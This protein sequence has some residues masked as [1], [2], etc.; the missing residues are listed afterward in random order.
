MPWPA[1]RLQ[2]GAGRLSRFGFIIRETLRNV[3]SNWIEAENLEVTP[4]IHVPGYKF[5]TIIPYG[6][7]LYDPHLCNWVAQDGSVPI[8]DVGGQPR[9]TIFDPHHGHGAIWWLRPDDR[10]E[11]AVPWGHVQLGMPMFPRCAPPSFG[12]WA[13]HFLILA[14]LHPGRA[15]AHWDHVIQKWDGRSD[16][17]ETFAI[18]P[19]NN[20]AQG[21][22]IPS[23]LIPGEFGPDGTEYEGSYFCTALRNNT[24]YRI[25]GNGRSESHVIL[26]GRDNPSLLPR[27]F[28]F[29]SGDN[30]PDFPQY[31]GK[32]IV[33]GVPNTN[34]TATG[35]DNKGRVVGQD[36]AFHVIEDGRCSPEPF[37]VGNR[38]H[39]FPSR[40][41][42]TFGPL[43]NSL[44]YTD[45]GSIMQSQS[46][47][48]FDAYPHDAGVH[49]RDQGGTLRPFVTDLRSGRNDMQFAGN[50]LL[51]TNW[52]KSYST[53]EF[54][55]ADGAIWEIVYD[56][57]GA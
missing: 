25:F 54:H 37:F 45:H 35:D 33:G 55:E 32:M 49:Y 56:P 42:S 34:F 27:A 1:D 18:L 51:I 24:I 2:R 47:R 20:S 29:G 11:P 21:E 16:R 4:T 19:R 57:A 26:D 38:M 48:D 52:G 44:F 39:A 53:G 46:I 28:C 15:G 10:L 41:P 8:C 3:M 14:Q 9:N 43:S 22:G 23:A 31:R 13:G 12:H 5:R 50:R 40:A 17:F 30:F 6:D 7:V 36:V